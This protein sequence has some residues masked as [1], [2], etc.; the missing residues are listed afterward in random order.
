V[1]EVPRPRREPEQSASDES[2]KC[3]RLSI[4]PRSFVV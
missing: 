1:E 3:G 2:K 4:R